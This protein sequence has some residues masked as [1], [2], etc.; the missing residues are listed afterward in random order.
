VY[1]LSQAY[2]YV[3]PDPTETLVIY[4]PGW[5][6]TPT[7]VSAEA[8]VQGL[9]YKHSRVLVVDT[10]LTFSR[11][12]LSSVS[13]VNPL[14]TLLYKFLSELH[15]MG[16]PLSSVHLIGFS[17]GSHVSAIAGK[18]VQKNLGVKIGRITALDPAKPCFMNPSHH[19]LHISDAE[20]VH[21]IHSS[22]VGLHDP[23]GHID[24]YVN[25]VE[26]KQPE[27]LDRELTLECDHSISWKHYAA[28]VTDDGAMMGQYCSNWDELMRDQ[29]TGPMA[30]VG[31]SCTE[32]TRGIFMFKSDGRIKR[33]EEARRA[34]FNLFD[35]RTWW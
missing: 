8:L 6:N 15:K 3:D 2:K 25:G 34:A 7:D 33:M 23:L 13:L 5:M 17:L 22:T 12:Y 1:R 35:F 19:R 32:K 16:F 18:L 29:C 31:Y 21:V 27:C 26:V 20:F 24:V 4:I 9:L 14:G 11:G 30:P 28:S 10:L